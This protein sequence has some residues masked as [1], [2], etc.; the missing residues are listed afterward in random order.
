MRIFHLDVFMSHKSPRCKI[1]AIKLSGSAEV[2]YGFLV[3]RSER[4]KIAW[5]QIQHVS[6]EINQLHTYKTANF[7]TVSVQCEEFGG[8]SR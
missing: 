7:W 5:Y 4:M 8:Q 3:L 1:G 2:F 6:T